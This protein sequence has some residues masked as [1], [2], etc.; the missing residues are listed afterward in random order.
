M[1]LVFGSFVGLLSWFAWPIGLIVA[2]LLSFELVRGSRRVEGISS[3]RN[4]ESICQF[5]RSFTRRSI[6][7]WILRATHEGLSAH[8]GFSVRAG[9]HLEQDL[10]VDPE[11]LED[12]LIEIATRANRCLERTES[13]PWFGR[14]FTVHDLVKFLDHQP[15][16]VPKGC[17]S[18]VLC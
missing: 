2:G 10:E 12:E 3:A 18:S 14:V 15:V 1:V 11:D 9:D 16:L 17:S 5:A 8:C 13:N 6:D 7:P 4:G